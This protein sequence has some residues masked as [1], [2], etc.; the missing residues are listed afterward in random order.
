MGLIDA[1]VV[2]GLLTS[3]LDPTAIVQGELS[4][5]HLIDSEVTHAPYDG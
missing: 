4:A 5:P 1:G 3:D 2:I